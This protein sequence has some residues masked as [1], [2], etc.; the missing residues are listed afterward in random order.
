M[1]LGPLEEYVDGWDSDEQPD[2]VGA[3]RPALSYWR[4]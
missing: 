1:N 2:V 3:V 4:N